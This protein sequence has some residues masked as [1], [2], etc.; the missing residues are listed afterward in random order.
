M[1]GIKF[2]KGENSITI[3]KIYGEAPYMVDF[4]F[5]TPKLKGMQKD[6]SFASLALKLRKEN[7]IIQNDIS[8]EHKLDIWKKIMALIK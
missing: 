8:P 6:K 2:N 4:L 5:E 1:I 7:F 3:L